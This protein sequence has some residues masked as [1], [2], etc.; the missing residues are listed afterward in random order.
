[1]VP[2]Y[3]RR[4]EIAESIERTICGACPSVASGCRLGALRSCRPCWHHCLRSALSPQSRAWARRAS[5]VTAVSRNRD[6]LARKTRTPGLG[7]D[8]WDLF[9]LWHSRSLAPTVLPGC[10]YIAQVP[11]PREQITFRQVGR[12]DGQLLSEL[13]RFWHERSTGIHQLRSGS[14]LNCCRSKHD[15]STCAIHA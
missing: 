8:A 14:I 13:T 11:T 4:T 3:G 15:I 7:V 6:R 10:I 12:R 2:A 1:M 5:T 9:D